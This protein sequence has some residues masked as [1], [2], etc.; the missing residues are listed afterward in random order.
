MIMLKAK[1]LYTFSI[2]I[3]T[4][5]ESNSRIL[6]TQNVYACT[7]DQAIKKIKLYYK[8]NKIEIE[9]TGVNCNSNPTLF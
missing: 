1:Q 7:C 2:K 9:I 5:I 6:H 3:L 4:K 8:Q